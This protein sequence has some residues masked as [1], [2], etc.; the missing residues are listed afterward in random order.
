VSVMTAPGHGVCHLWQVSVDERPRQLR[1]PESDRRHIAL[2]RTDEARAIAEA[3][4]WATR[5]VLAHYVDALPEELP[6]VRPHVS[7][8]GTGRPHLRDRD[9]DF[10]VANTHEHVMVAVVG[11]GLVGVD[12]ESSRALRMSE[13][14]A[15]AI[16][17]ASEW[18]G[19][20]AYDGDRRRV[21][22]LR[23]FCRKE[24]VLKL[25]G[26]GLATDPR[27]V[28]V[29]GPIARL[30]PDPSWAATTTIHLTDLSHGPMGAI[31]TTSSLAAVH[32]FDG[33]A[34]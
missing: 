11:A 2:M 3:S 13:S 10:S 9:V 8:S 25:L 19:F 26:T 17:S 12:T 29:A 4:R 34:L 5:Q 18:A 24:A 21:E 22:V 15:S 23:L 33:A 20:E 14:V 6:I 31:A 32:V 27:T 16:C 28:D 1:L 7:G 30:G